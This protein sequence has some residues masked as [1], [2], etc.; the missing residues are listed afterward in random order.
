MSLGEF[1]LS[2]KLF[3]FSMAFH[4]RF[5]SEEARRVF[6]EFFAFFLGTLLFAARDTDFKLCNALTLSYIG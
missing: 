4:P 3:L 2:L 1:S 6:R 5:L